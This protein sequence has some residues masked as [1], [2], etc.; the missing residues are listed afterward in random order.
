MWETQVQS[1]DREI[2]WKRKW[3]PTSVFLPRESWGQRI[4]AG[5]SPWGG[6]ES[7]KESDTTEGLNTFTF[8]LFI[9]LAWETLWTDEP[10]R[11]QSMGPQKSP[12]QLSN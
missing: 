1:L 11:L 3:Q 9:I 5:Y 6:K 12:I 4:L 8:L 7:G 10:G 2:P